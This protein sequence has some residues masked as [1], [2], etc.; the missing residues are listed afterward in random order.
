MGVCDPQSTGHNT[1][2]VH[3]CKNIPRRSM[4]SVS[5]LSSNIEHKQQDQQAPSVTAEMDRIVALAQHDN[6][7]AD[8]DEHSVLSRHSFSLYEDDCS[9]KEESKYDDSILFD[10]IV[11][12]RGGGTSTEQ[13]QPESDTDAA[14]VTERKTEEEDLTDD[15]ITQHLKALTN[16]SKKTNSSSYEDD[17][18]DTEDSTSSDDMSLMSHDTA[19]TL[20]DVSLDEAAYAKVDEVMKQLGVNI[21]TVAEKENSRQWLQSVRERNAF[22][23]ADAPQSFSSKK[24]WLVNLAADFLDEDDDQS[25]S[26]NLTEMDHIY[27]ES[28]NGLANETKLAETLIAKSSAGE[29]Q[30]EPYAANTTAT[31]ESQFKPITKRQWKPPS[32]PVKATSRAAELLAKQARALAQKQPAAPLLPQSS[33]M[34]TTSEVVSE[35]KSRNGKSQDTGLRGNKY[36]QEYEPR[37]V[38]LDETKAEDNGGSAARESPRDQQP[39]PYEKPNGRTRNAKCSKAHRK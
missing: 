5:T 33:V 11:K 18:S 28:R 36:C 12:L 4:D 16:R 17:V 39:Q 37:E 19:F 10:L 30:Q 34:A 35:D 27:E 3:T 29:P 6:D 15:L 1:V 32:P 8:D 25:V 2:L 14:G 24:Q 38:T 21:D 23:F 9:V 22:D 20:D 7:N 13:T 31:T 26:T